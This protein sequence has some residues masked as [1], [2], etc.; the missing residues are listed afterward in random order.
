MELRQA[1]PHPFLLGSPK[2]A[3]THPRRRQLRARLAGWRLDRALAAGTDPRTDPLLACRAEQLIAPEARRCLAE[4]LRDTL[5]QATFGAALGSA[6]PLAAASLRANSDPLLALASR[7]ESDR[8]VGPAGVSRARLLLV[9][10]DSPIYRPADPLALEN[11]LEAAL[12]GL[13]G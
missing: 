13:G 1:I 8:T 11:A 10:G 9:D 2:R 4:S 6:V 5:A 3:A 12:I 7:L